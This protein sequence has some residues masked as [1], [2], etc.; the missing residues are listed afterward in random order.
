MM[1][2][3]AAPIARCARANLDAAAAELAAEINRR[4]AGAERRAKALAALAF[5][6]EITAEV[7]MNTPP[8]GRVH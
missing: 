6:V 8:E 4:I 5:V 3:G 2:A 1:S 7:M